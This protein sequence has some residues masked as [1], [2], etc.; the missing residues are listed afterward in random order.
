M[1]KNV[2]NCGFEIYKA[3]LLV[4]PRNGFLTTRDILRGFKT[5]YW[6]GAIGPEITRRDADMLYWPEDADICSLDELGLHDKDY[7]TMIE[8]WENCNGHLQ[9]TGLILQTNR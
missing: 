7:D 1:I 9:L 4:Y 6:L 5:G 3:A 2:G 8:W